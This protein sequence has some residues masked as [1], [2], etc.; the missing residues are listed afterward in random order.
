M[1]EY[2]KQHL[3]KFEDGCGTKFE[4]GEIKDV[5]DGAFGLRGYGVFTVSNEEAYPKRH[6]G[7]ATLTIRQQSASGAPLYWVIIPRGLVA[8]LLDGMD[9]R[10]ANLVQQPGDLVG[11]LTKNGEPPCVCKYPSSHDPSCAWK[12]WK[13][14][15]ED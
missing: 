3:E 15:Q 1:K 6:S 7:H 13:D 5:R 9:Y 11:L 10:I 8:D 12:I 14:K 4:I 2:T